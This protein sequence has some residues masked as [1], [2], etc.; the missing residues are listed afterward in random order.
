[1][2]ELKTEVQTDEKSVKLEIIQKEVIKLLGDI[3][4]LIENSKRSITHHNSSQKYSQFQQQFSDATN[5]VADLQLR[6]SIVAPMKAGKSTIINA[7]AGQELLPSCASAMTT[8]PTEIVF[9]SGLSEPVL[10]LETET[11][12][13]FQDIYEKISDKI[14]RSGIKSLEEEIAR[15]PHLTYLLTKIEDRANLSLFPEIEGRIA[16]NEVLNDLNH[17]IRL[18]SAIEPLAEPLAELTT[19]PRIQTPFLGLAGIEQAKTLGDLVIIDTPGPNESGAN[20]KLT[21]VVEEQ[22]RRS[23]IILIVLDYT[24]LNNEAAEAIKKQ[25]KPILKLIGKEN[26]YVLINKIDQRRRGDMTSEQ[27]R[28]FVL[29]DLDLDSDNAENRIFELSAIRAFA[30]TQFLLEISQNPQADLLELNSLETLAQEVFGI[31][32][33]EELEDI[34]LKIL[35]KKARKLW[36]KSGFAPFLEKAIAKLMESAAP[37]SLI[38]ALNLSRYR[39]LELR[40]DINLR[41]KAITKS[42]AKLKQEIQALESD[43]VCLEAC[44]NNLKQVEEIKFQLHNTL[45]VIIT[46]LKQKARVNLETYFAQK[47][48]EQGDIIKKADIKARELLVTNIGDFKILPEFLSQNLKSNLEPKTTG[49]INFST[50]KEAEKFTQEALICAKQRLENLLLLSRQKI[51]AEI[52]KTNRDLKSFLRKETQPIVKRAQTRLKKNFEIDLELPSPTINS[53]ENV[54]IEDPLIKKKTR[55]VD[56]GYEERLVKKRAWYYWFGIVPFYSQ[57]MHQKPYKKENYYAISAYE[58]IDRINFTNDRLIDDI[59]LKL[60]N[61]LEEDI[62]Q[63][64]DSFFTSLD[65]YFGSYLKNIQQVQQ[66]KELSLEQRT[67]IIKF[68]YCLLP[69][70]TTYI[71]KT[72][73]YLQIAEELLTIKN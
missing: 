24:Q 17:I 48:Y 52:T 73:N 34:N 60:L 45:E 16:I 46:D 20:L 19:I 15:Y 50:E 39:L 67:K 13:M 42:K 30:A 72:D 22:L 68:L 27:V 6:M 62:Q 47:E 29:A 49:I 53:Q 57:E 41:G 56:G 63:Q 32:W 31:D 33:D 2:L 40:D 61:Y 3:S 43:L 38:A 14:K 44:R 37:R 18:Y 11:I 64:V 21:A 59:T 8:I 9:S 7:I 28:D 4:N 23:S 35:Q 69:E 65:E 58:L 5:N 66:S 10:K 1:M 71:E 25:V 70:T 51:E 26:L 12:Q 55:L 36:K 54:R